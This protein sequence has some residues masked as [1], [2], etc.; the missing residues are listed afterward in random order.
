VV[1]QPYLTLV[2][3]A[4]SSMMRTIQT[5]DGKATMFLKLNWMK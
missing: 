4:Q 2:L 3:L 5:I 1:R